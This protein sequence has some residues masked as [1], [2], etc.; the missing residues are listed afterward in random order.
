MAGW[1]PRLGFALAGALLALGP[2]SAAVQAAPSHP[3][4]AV[5]GACTDSTGIT[6]VVDFTRFGDGVEVRCAPQ[7]V[8]SAFEA[9]TRAG[10]AFQ[11]TVRFPGLLCRIDGEPATDP[12]Q[13][14]PPPN[15]YWAYW[16]AP[17]GGD[18]TYSTSG[19]GTRVPPPGSV[20][21]WAF[22]DE[23]A[24][25]IDP[26]A[27]L[28]TTTTR[29]ATTSTTGP[30]ADATDATAPPTTTGAP[31]ATSTTVSPA[32]AGPTTT[33]AEPRD[34]PRD[35][36]AP[37][38]DALVGAPSSRDDPPSGG[39]SPVGAVIGVIVAAAL[40]V[41]ALRSAHRRRGVEEEPA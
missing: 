32:A 33:S 25:G 2:S 8:R 15:A 13:G 17:R 16:H 20:E 6:V 26:P 39:G 5:G 37:S 19:G 21:G 23:D 10:F 36:D 7:P 4:T 35:G 9:L 11:G 29:P 28:T 18:W 14:A 34:A 1:V 27:P 3:P 40:G 12:C 30:S 24:P 38:R 41:A 22:G 31:D